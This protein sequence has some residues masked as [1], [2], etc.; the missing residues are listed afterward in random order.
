M[1]SQLLSSGAFIKAW[2]DL[3]IHTKEVQTLIERVLA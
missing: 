1:I 3:S 2:A